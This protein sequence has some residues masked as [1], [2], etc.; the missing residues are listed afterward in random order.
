M[1]IYLK[2]WRQTA[3]DVEGRLVDYTIEGVNQDMSFLEMLD[4]LNERLIKKGEDAVEF[5]NDCREGICGACGLMV[6]GIAH[7]PM[8]ATAICQLHMRHFDDGDTIVVEPFRAEAFPIVRDLVVDRSAFDRIIAAGGYVSVNTGGTPDANSVPVPKQNADEAFD[9]AACIGCGA[10]VAACPNS[11][12]SLFTG[13]K[14]AHLAALP[15]GQVERKRRVVR[16]VD[17][18]EAEGFGDCSNHAECEAVCPKEI[19]IVAIARMRREYVRAL[20]G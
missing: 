16:M 7:G 5:D 20:F 11:S 1:T 6:G 13:A 15:Q 9:F 4:V 19:S 2:V 10:C 8:K 18:M 3:P 17:Q 12:A 14:V